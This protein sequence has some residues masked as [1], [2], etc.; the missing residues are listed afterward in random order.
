MLESYLKT[1]LIYFLVEISISV[2]EILWFIY[3]QLKYGIKKQ[4]DPKKFIHVSA[5]IS[6]KMLDIDDRK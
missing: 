4:F 6:D 1:K 5:F 3:S 2:W